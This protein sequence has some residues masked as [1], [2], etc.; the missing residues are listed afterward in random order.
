[1]FPAVGTWH[2][3]WPSD[4]RT[5]FPSLGS[6]RAHPTE[7]VLRMPTPTS[8]ASLAAGVWHVTQ[9]DALGLA[10]RSGAVETKER[11]PEDP[12]GLVVGAVALVGGPRGVPIE[13]VL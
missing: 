9:S 7:Q 4:I 1:M 12:S 8:P 2:C 5:L 6:R 13:Q 10:L 11:G 3:C